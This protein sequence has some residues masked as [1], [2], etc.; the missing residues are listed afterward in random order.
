VKNLLFTILKEIKKESEHRL[1]GTF[2]T[3]AI[4]VVETIAENYTKLPADV[5]GLL[6]SIFESVSDVAKKAA[7]VLDDP[8]RDILDDYPLLFNVTQME[9]VKD[10][11]SMI[12]ANYNKLPQNVT[13]FLSKIS[14]INLLTL[15]VA[16]FILV[17]Y[18]KLPENPKNLLYDMLRKREPESG[19][20]LEQ[21]QK[22]WGIMNDLIYNDSIPERTKNELLLDVSRWVPIPKGWRTDQTDIFK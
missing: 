15:D 9:I 1:P 5:K 2:N 14:K 3:H 22:G 17:N 11:I 7:A 6:S 19:V 18:D 4:G 13:N 10:M 12:A 16:N 8:N 20:R 21:N